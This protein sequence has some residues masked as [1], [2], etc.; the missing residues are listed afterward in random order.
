MRT[1]KKMFILHPFS[2][3]SGRFEKKKRKKEKER[4]GLI[5]ILTP[6]ASLLTRKKDDVI[7]KEV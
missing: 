3:K 2:P 4:K 6:T 7:T 1:P 5:M